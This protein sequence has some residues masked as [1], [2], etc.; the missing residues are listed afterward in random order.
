MA[1][2]SRLFPVSCAIILAA[3][4]AACAPEETRLAAIQRE[5]E[6]IRG[7][8]FK[9]EVPA[10]VMSRQDLVRRMIQAGAIPAPSGE[11][12]AGEAAK[13]CLGLV[14]PRPAADAE[15]SPPPPRED[16]IR[17]PIG[18]G[19]GVYRSPEE[20]V[21]LLE[22]NGTPGKTE[23]VLAHELYHALQDQ[24]W[25]LDT[26]P[27]DPRPNEDL[28]M[29]MRALIEGE[30]VYLQNAF[31]MKRQGRGL[32][33]LADFTA[34][35]ARQGG[36]GLG[37]RPPYPALVQFFTYYLG[38]EFVAAVAREGGWE[39]VGKIY[40]DLPASTEQILH[41]ERYL[42]RDRPQEID[43]GA[44][45]PGPDW[46]PACRNTLGEFSTRALLRIQK[47]PDP[48]AA[49]AGWDGDTYRAFRGP[50]GACLVVWGSVWD[51]EEDA[52]AFEGAFLKTLEN[53]HAGLARA[54]RATP[55]PLYQTPAG[56]SLVLERREARVVAVLGTSSAEQAE[57]LAAQAWKGWSVREADKI[58]RVAAPEKK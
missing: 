8:P 10:R 29:A 40:A 58:G 30:A 24:H 18:D 25:D 50:A 46:T 45:D 55:P 43:L 26:L 42:S 14:P 39:A 12:L 21:W 20:E 27:T 16:Q 9:R 3:G 35:N 28:S 52:R 53:R 44:L 36:R 13:A 49:A 5:V 17:L 31:M 57:R 48:V 6:A 2:L 11:A 56:E 22:G 51:T 23:I 41:P 34:Q 19:E 38:S 33:G 32:E 54:E 37:P 1:P 7:L 47:A 15:P 4:S